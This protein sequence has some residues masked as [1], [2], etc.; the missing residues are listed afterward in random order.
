MSWKRRA[1][2]LALAALSACASLLPLPD[3]SPL[4]WT[5]EEFHTSASFYWLALTL[6]ATGF[7]GFVLVLGVEGGFWRMRDEGEVLAL[8]GGGVLFTFVACCAGATLNLFLVVNWPMAA[9]VFSTVIVAVAGALWAVEGHS[10]ESPL[11]S[12]GGPEAL[13][14]LAGFPILQLGVYLMASRATGDYLLPWIASVP[15]CLSVLAVGYFGYLLLEPLFPGRHQQVRFGKL[16]LS[17]KGI[18]SILLGGS[19]LGFGVILFFY[20][21]RFQRDT[22]EMKTVLN[23]VD[24]LN[25]IRALDQRSREAGKTGEPK[26]QFLQREEWDLREKAFSGLLELLKGCADFSTSSSRRAGQALEAYIG[27]ALVD[28]EKLHDTSKLLRSARKGLPKYD[29]RRSQEALCEAWAQQIRAEKSAQNYTVALELLRLAGNDVGA[30]LPEDE[31]KQLFGAWFR[32]QVQRDAPEF[33]KLPPELAETVWNK[34]VQSRNQQERI[35]IA[36]SSKSILF[37]EAGKLNSL[38]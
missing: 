32:E 20:G 29:F 14:I 10:I 18:V 28:R 34:M 31:K 11:L 22:E 25:Q 24:T 36:L 27:G 2:L 16:V 3:T 30:V 8:L 4:I 33:A 19:A 7:L 1:L 15:R 5:G 23:I 26:P 35:F 13:C 12:G 17:W 37:A 6:P 21:G 38:R 9:A